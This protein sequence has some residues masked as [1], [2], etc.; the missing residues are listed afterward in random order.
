MINLDISEETILNKKDIN[1]SN[2][3]TLTYGPSSKATKIDLIQIHLKTTIE[4][5]IEEGRV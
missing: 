5:R 4:E 1:S 3:L 2:P